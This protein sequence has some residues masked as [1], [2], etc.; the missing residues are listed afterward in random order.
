[1]WEEY[2]PVV[3]LFGSLGF[4]AILILIAVWMA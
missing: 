2:W 3:A 1:M 4:L